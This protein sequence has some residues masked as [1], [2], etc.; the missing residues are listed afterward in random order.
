MFHPPPDYEQKKCFLSA[1]LFDEFQNWI[2]KNKPGNIAKTSST[3]FGRFMGN[4]GKGIEGKHT[5]EGK[6]YEI[7]PKKLRED[8]NKF[9]DFLY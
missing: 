6:M 7:D 5:N 9:A 2:E 8:F 1:D 3:A 4:Y